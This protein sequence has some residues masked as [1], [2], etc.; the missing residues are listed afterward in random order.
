MKNTAQRF[1]RVAIA[2]ARKG[3]EKGNRPFGAAIVRGAKVV[4]RAHSTSFSGRDPTAH[5]ELDAIRRFFKTSTKPDLR[6][7]AIY[8]TGE[9]CP[10]CSASIAWAKLSALFIAA[11]HTDMPPVMQRAKR[12]G[13]VTYKEILRELGAKIKV[14][15]GVLRE[16]VIKLYQEFVKKQA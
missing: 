7:H 1:M 16:E 9:P 5:A 14:T 4:A 13:K 2:E 12:L 10:M 8:A 6:G 15:K 3:M 11:N